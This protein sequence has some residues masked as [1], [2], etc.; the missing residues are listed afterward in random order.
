MGGVRATENGESAWH[1]AAIVQV[2][3]MGGRVLCSP[4]RKGAMGAGGQASKV[5]W[6]SPSRVSWLRW[7]E[8]GLGGLLGLEL[9]EG[10]ECLV[11]S[12]S[13]WKRNRQDR[14]WEANHLKF[15]CR[16]DSLA[17]DALQLLNVAQV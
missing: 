1:F 11:E 8:L 13:G 5:V 14:R 16:R 17:A 12:E 2:A 3:Q 9:L 10:V 7:G 4:G 15:L 6:S